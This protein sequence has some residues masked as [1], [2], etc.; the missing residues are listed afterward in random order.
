MISGVEDARRAVR[1]RIG[2]GADFI[3]VYEVWNYPTL[4]VEEMS[5]IVEEAHNAGREVAAHAT[6]PEGRLNAITAGVDSIKHGHG[7]NRQDLE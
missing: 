6:S 7:A 1:E 2:N 5:I 3:K 4:T